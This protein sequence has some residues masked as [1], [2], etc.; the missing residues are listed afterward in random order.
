MMGR[1]SRHWAGNWLQGERRDQ[2]SQRVLYFNPS[3]EAQASRVFLP[4]WV[5][6]IAIH[7]NGSRSGSTEPVPQGCAENPPNFAPR[8]CWVAAAA[9]RWVTWLD[10]YPRRLR[11]TKCD[12]G[13]VWHPPR[14]QPSSC[15]IAPLRNG[16]CSCH[17]QRINPSDPKPISNCDP[18]LADR[19]IGV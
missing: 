8:R 17:T 16:P 5:S 11:I 2:V 1:S 10:G 9:P 6:L 18:P 15:P 3:L 14:L 7:V 12:A 13:Y 4:A 19:V